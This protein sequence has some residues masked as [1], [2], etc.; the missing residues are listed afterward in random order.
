M[1]LTSIYLAEEALSLEPEHRAQLAKL[2]L[3]SL[4]EDGRSDEAVRLALCTRLADLKSGTDSGLSFE[5]IFGPA[6]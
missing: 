2:L 4:E 1:S 5:Q 6:V 3:Q